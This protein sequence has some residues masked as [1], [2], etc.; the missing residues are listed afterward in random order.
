MIS[1][2]DFQ[3]SLQLDDVPVEFLPI[4]KALWW[5]KHGNWEK[6]HDLAQEISTESGSWLHAILHRWEGD[7]S[8]AKYWYLLANRQFPEISVE[9]EIDEMIKE[10]FR[11]ID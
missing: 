3:K 5:A 8:N 1:F 7:I 2:D 9:K 11:E 10:L 6:A 4:E